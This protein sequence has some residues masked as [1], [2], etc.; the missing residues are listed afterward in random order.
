MNH[1]ATLPAAQE[2]TAVDGYVEQ[3]LGGGRRESVLGSLPSHVRPEVFER[4]LVNAVMSNPDFL[5]MDPR[6][7][8]REV[9][10]VAALGLFLDPQ[11]GEGYLIA[12]WNKKAKR[13][14]P[15]LRIGYRGLVKL[16]RQSGDVSKVY[17]HEV[18]ANDE[19]EC[20]L[21]D[22]KRLIHKPQI[23]GERGDV[24]GYYAVVI[25]KQGEPD[26]E[27]MTISQIN[28]I[29]D[30]SDGWKAFS[31]N[32]IRS[33]PWSTDYGE[34]AK[35]TVMR[36][37]LKRIPQ[38]P[39][40]ADAIHIED[41]AEHSEIHA[42]AR[43]AAV[44]S[45]PDIPPPPPDEPI[46]VEVNDPAQEPAEAETVV[47]GAKVHDPREDNPQGRSKQPYAEMGQPEP[48]I[49][50]DAYDGTIEDL[51]SRLADAPDATILAEVWDEVQAVWD[52]VL[53]PDRAEL[54]NAYNE[55]LGAFED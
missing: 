30:R 8:Y 18:C 11:L 12:G 24:V 37:L 41:R 28:E 15:Q 53:D 22:D 40:V 3:V 49:A 13:K 46:D 16:A 10:K 9:S 2:K 54:N 6:L 31:E 45:I 1:V 50:P 32:K 5:Q 21:G 48:L 36:R 27:I 26:F 19:F 34:M 33:T 38:S 44:P 20:L 29:R 52:E 17:A 43:L 25:Y 47:E 7:V 42:P 4:N 14:E 55:R 35:K 23:F 51:R 39:E